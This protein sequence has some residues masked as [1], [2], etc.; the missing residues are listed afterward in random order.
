MGEDKLCSLV[1]LKIG[2]VVYLCSRVI[3]PNKV[4]IKE[5][6]HPLGPALFRSFDGFL[7]G[8]C[9]EEGLPEH[10]EG[11]PALSPEEVPLSLAAVYTPRLQVAG[12][13]H[14]ERTPAG[15]GPSPKP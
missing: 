7:T 9:P 12:G 11:L 15:R 13:R 4:L 3:S 1:Q 2:N 10:S 6:S 14:D 8:N 5:K